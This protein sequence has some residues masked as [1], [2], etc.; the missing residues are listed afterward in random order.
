[1]NVLK[2]LTPREDGVIALRFGLEG[3][4][5]PDAGRTGAGSS[6]SPGAGAPDRGQSPAQ[7]PPPPAGPS[8]CGI[9]WMNKLHCRVNGDKMHKGVLWL[10]VKNKK[11]NPKIRQSIHVPGC[12]I[13]EGLREFFASKRKNGLTTGVSGV[14]TALVSHNGLVRQKGE[15]AQHE[16]N[17]SYRKVCAKR[18]TSAR[19]CSRIMCVAQ[20]RPAF[21]TSVEYKSKEWLIL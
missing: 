5:R 7:A 19:G 3:W 6:T 10:N 18:R 8:A 15:F 20:I 11:I 13:K 1:M 17:G 16:R 4:P 9:I 14:Y 2:S 12:P 21:A